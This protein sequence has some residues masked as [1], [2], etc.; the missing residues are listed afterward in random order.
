MS[1]VIVSKE[2]G[3]SVCELT[4]ENNV[5]KLNTKLYRAVPALEYLVNLNKEIKRNS[6]N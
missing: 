2:T 4:N 5:K 1:W 3:K 6:Q